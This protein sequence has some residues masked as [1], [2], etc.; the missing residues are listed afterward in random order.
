MVV[1]QGLVQLWSG[2]VWA[3]VVVRSVQLQFMLG[4]ELVRFVSVK[5]ESTLVNTVWCGSTQSTVVN[6]RSTT[7]KLVNSG[8][9]VSPDSITIQLVSVMVQDWFEWVNWF[10]FGFR[11]NTSTGQTLVNDSQLSGQRRSTQDPV[12]F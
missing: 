5:P 2:L 6:A 12:K 1:Q 8:Q 11:V 4:S 10:R 7:V 3:S 9:Q